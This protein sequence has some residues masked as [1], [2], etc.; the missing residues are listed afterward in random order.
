MNEKNTFYYTYSSTKNSEVQEI[1][2][3][4]L[5]PEENKLELLKHLDNSVKNAGLVSSLCTGII[6]CLVFGIGLCFA[7]NILGNSMVFGIILGIFGTLMMGAAY[8]MYLNAVKK[9]KEELTP[10]ILALADELIHNDQ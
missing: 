9:K 5:P 8:P 10:R 1:R 4:Y 2:K 7:M 6:G 3:K